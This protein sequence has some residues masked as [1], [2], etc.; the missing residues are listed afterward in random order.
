MTDSLPV[1]KWAIIGAGVISKRFISDILL[2]RPD[3]KAKHRV[4]AI[5][6]S[7]LEKADQF[8]KE[9]CPNENARVYGSYVEAAGDADVDVVYVGTP[10]GLHKKQVL[11]FIRLGKN[12]VCEKAFTINAREAIELAEAAR[13]NDVFLMEA[14]WTRFF[15]LVKKLQSLVHDENAIGHVARVFVD[16]AL[17]LDVINLPATSRYKNLS[18]GAGALLDLGVYT[19]TLAK[20]VLDNRIGD[21]SVVPEISAAQTLVEGVDVISSVV[22]TYPVGRQAI[23]TVA[24]VGTK[25]DHTF[26]KIE[27]TEGTITLSGNLTSEPERLTITKNNGQSQVFEFSH[28][29]W[30]FYY[31]A[32]AVAIDLAQ[33]KKEDSTMPLSESIFVLRLLDRIRKIGGLVYPHDSP[34]Y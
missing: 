30:G 34:N 15:P 24:T 33:G 20:V 10:H 28:P 7:S 27:G 1:A 4:V 14:M 31:E 19:V 13:D 26:M 8:A 22:L 3:A 6:A 11:D 17:K 12:V 9:V 21:H 29:G 23:L 32:D 5:G 18:L 16:F 2:S 25:S